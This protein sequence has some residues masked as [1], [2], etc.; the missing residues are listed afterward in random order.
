MAQLGTLITGA[1]V[2]TIIAGQAQCE[3]IVVIGSVSTA[4]PLQGLQVEVDGIPFINISNQAALLSAYAKW[5][6]QFVST[7]MGVV[8]KIA[9]GR[10]Y[11]STT[12][13]FINNGATTPIIYAYS[14]AED[15]VPILAGTKSINAGSFD[16][17][18]SFSALFISAPANIASAEIV[19]RNGTKSTLTSQEL[20]AMFSMTSSSEANGQL[21]GCTVIDNRMRV[22]ESVRLYATGAA[23]TILV[24]KIPDG[25]FEVL[26]SQGLIGD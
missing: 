5:M 24:A 14:D 23:L 26:K 12:Y 19:F 25:S 7:L 6:S 8:F 20:D 17:F 10:I 1:G 9:T 18:Q 3:S 11:K 15:G 2:P 13:R 4:N 21:L 16:D 22:I